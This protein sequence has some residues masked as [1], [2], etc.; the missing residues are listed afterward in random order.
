MTL[1]R[2]KWPQV[3][4]ALPASIQLLWGRSR[5]AREFDVGTTVYDS[6]MSGP[7][8]REALKLA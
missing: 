7:K 4:S 8:V 2:S 5:A 3:S 1:K 6:N